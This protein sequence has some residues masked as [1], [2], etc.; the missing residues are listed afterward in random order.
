MEHCPARAARQLGLLHLLTGDV[1]AA[2]GVLAKA[3]GLGWSSEDHPGHVL[4]S[5]CAGLLAEGTG[6]THGAELFAGLK[7]PLRDP[8]DA[9]WDSGDARP[10][11][12]TMPSI[13]ELIALAHSNID[14]EDREVVLE[15]M[16]AAASRRVEG[17]LSHRRRHH[18]GHAA[19][20]VACCL[21]VAPTVGKR[22]EL[23]DWVDGVRKKYSR[24]Y[25]FQQEL[26]TAL[27]SSSS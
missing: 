14:P 16:R 10:P 15:A 26:T 5:A 4:F 24:F 17:I 22:K 7:E 3:P 27:A 20:L 13:G 23:A 11:R 8:L 2:A 6:A 19:A 21:E 9:D 18:Y 12:L 1:Q 25:A